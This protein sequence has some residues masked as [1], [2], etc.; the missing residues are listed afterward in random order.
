LEKAA[1]N[2]SSA[3]Q[4]TMPLPGRMTIRAPLKPPTTRAQRSGEMRSWSHRRAT[5]VAITGVNITMAVNSAT[6]MRRNAAKAIAD[7]NASSAPRAIWNIG[8]AQ[9]KERCLDSVIHSVM[10]A[11]CSP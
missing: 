2:G 6:G 8:L 9:R 10:I 7:E 3:A 11:A 1:A 4:P 5:S